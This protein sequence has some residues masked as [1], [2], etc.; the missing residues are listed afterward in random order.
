MDCNTLLQ[1]DVRDLFIIR[2]Y[3]PYFIKNDVLTLKLFKNV[4]FYEDN[5][6]LYVYTKNS[7]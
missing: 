7:F 6:S 4:W 3:H 2:M 1:I 5:K